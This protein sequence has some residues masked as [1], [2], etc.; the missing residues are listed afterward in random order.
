VAIL[1]NVMLASTGITLFKKPISDLPCNACLGYTRK[2]KQEVFL[3]PVSL[4]NAESVG[5]KVKPFKRLILRILIYNLA[6]QGTLKRNKC[7]TKMLKVSNS[8][9]S[10]AGRIFLCKIVS[11][12]VPSNY[13]HDGQVLNGVRIIT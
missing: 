5:L 8:S 3:N 11:C 1:N 4:A 7:N 12:K 10:H 6:F 9:K 13:S 2:N